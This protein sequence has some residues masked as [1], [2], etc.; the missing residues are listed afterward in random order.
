MIPCDSNALIR[1]LAGAGALILSF[2]A[3]AEEISGTAQVINGDTLIIAGQRI[4]VHNIEVPK[5]H[6]T[7]GSIATAR[8]KNVVQGKHVVC[9]VIKRDKF[10]P[11]VALCNVDG[12]DLKTLV[13]H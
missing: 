2:A 9:E 5:H 10:R 8:L 6:K 1:F 11:V 7:L 4:R 12:V 13:D 3:A